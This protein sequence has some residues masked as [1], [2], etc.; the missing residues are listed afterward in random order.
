MQGYS[1]CLRDSILTA[2]QAHSEI[3]W[4]CVV[5][6]FMSK[7]WTDL[8]SRSLENPDF[9]DL[10]LGGSR[11]R[12]IQQNIHTYARDIWLTRNEALHERNTASL[13]SI[14]TAEEAEIRSYFNHPAILHFD[15]R[16][17]CDKNIDTLLQSSTSNKSRW[18]CRA[19]ISKQTQERSGHSQTLLTSFFRREDNTQTQ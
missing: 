14:R 13:T 17:L 7:S 1:R 11:M 2:A 9:T 12:H 8:V 3:G 5:R 10:H 19:R 15:D 4:D 6:G 16:Y 18:L